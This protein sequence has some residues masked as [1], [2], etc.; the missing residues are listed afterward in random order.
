M[1]IHVNYAALAP[2]ATL[3]VFNLQ[4]RTPSWTA[5][6]AAA[7][8]PAA[9]RALYPQ[10]GPNAGVVAIE[11]VLEY[12][13]VHEFATL[14]SRLACAFAC[15]GL[16]GALRFAYTYRAQVNSHF[17]EVKPWAP[18]HYADM[19]LVS[20]GYAPGAPADVGLAE[21]HR[22]AREYWRSVRPAT[23]RSHIIPEVLMPGG[24]TVIR[25]LAIRGP[26]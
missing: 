7:G 18:V 22:R 6:L 11:A 2:G 23:S 20:R 25:Q 24:A 1:L 13:R 12:V 14:T 19:A 8:D 4:N 26:S 9:F 10:L 16:V 21:Q 17:Y 15:G 5:V 3:G